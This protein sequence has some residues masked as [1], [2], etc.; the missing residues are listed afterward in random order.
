MSIYKQ[1][2]QICQVRVDKCGSLEQEVV[3][4]L[5][6][7]HEVVKLAGELM[8][9]VKL[10]EIGKSGKGVRK[11]ASKQESEKKKKAKIEH[12]GKG[13]KAEPKKKASKKAEDPQEGEEGEKPEEGAEAKPEE[14]AEDEQAKIKEKKC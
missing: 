8:R 12:V 6:N 2:K 4:N 10:V 5:P 11:G 14:G 13:V 3:G 7:L 1:G 9:D